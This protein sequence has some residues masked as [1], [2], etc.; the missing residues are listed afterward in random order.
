MGEAQTFGGLAA[1]TVGA[2]EQAVTTAQADSR[3]ADPPDVAADTPRI[4][5]DLEAHTVALS[6]FDLL[7]LS[8]A[9]LLFADI[10]VTVAEVFA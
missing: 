4:I 10:V 3:A 7:L 5:L 2:D 8:T 1:S 9:T 6:G